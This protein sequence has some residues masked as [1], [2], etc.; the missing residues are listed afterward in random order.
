[1]TIKSI[2]A[3]VDG[4]EGSKRVLETAITLGH[5]FS[6]YVEVFHVERPSTPIIPSFVEGGGLIAAAEI[7]TAIA[8]EESDRRDHA[9]NL[10]QTMCVDA[11]L[12]IV[13]ADCVDVETEAGAGFSWKLVSGFEPR[14]LGHRGRLFD[15]IIM[16]KTDAQEGGVDSSQLEAALYDTGRLVFIAADD[17][18]DMS[19]IQVAVAWDGSREAARSVGLAIPILEI[20]NKVSVISVGD[21]GETIGASDLCRYLSRHGIASEY[22]PITKNGTSI[23]R[24]LIDESR[25]LKVDLLVMGAYGHSAVREYLFG[26]VT[27]ELLESGE[28]PLLLAH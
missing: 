4:A 1:M 21:K 13:D 22:V 16:A 15:L 3:C 18:I 25:N 23:A 17:N 12:N 27:R 2:L 19:K 26:G 10:F 28:L 11:G 7:T 6:A 9:K 5:T 14:E 24:H 8:Q 20:A